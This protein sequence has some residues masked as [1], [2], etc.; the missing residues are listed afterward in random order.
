MRHTRLVQALAVHQWEA[1]A[2]G[3][4]VSAGVALLAFTGPDTLATWLA[5]NA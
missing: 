3:A 1:L 5:A 4:A 2:E